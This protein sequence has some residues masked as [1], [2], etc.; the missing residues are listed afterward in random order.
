M[1]AGVPVIASNFPG[2]RDL[3]E[4]NGCGVV[5]DPL[6]PVELADAITYLLENEEI[7]ANMGRRGRAAIVKTYNWET[8]LPHLLRLYEGLLSVPDREV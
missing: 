2:W 8:Q 7:S 5:V 4:G 3:V 6:D 1:G